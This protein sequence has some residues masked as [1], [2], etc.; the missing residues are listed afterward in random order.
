MLFPWL[1]VPP[2]DPS[3]MTTYFGPAPCPSA[4]ELDADGAACW[5]QAS[6]PSAT[7]VKSHL[8]LRPMR[9]PPGRLPSCFV[10]ARE[11]AAR[12]ELCAVSF[13]KG[14]CHGIQVEATRP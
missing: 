8:V 12:R 4:A 13:L 9:P 10:E 1:L 11:R 2:S 14:D 3:G 5:P 6:A 7:T